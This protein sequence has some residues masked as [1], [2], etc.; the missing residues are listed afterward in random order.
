MLILGYKNAKKKHYYLHSSYLF[1]KVYTMKGLKK[2]KHR[3]KKRVLGKI[4]VE[5][6]IRLLMR[7]RQSVSPKKGWKSLSD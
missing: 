6:N 7:W 2:Q 5:I 3:R 4:G 1:N